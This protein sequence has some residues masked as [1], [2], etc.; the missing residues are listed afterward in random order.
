M[1]AAPRGH[2]KGLRMWKWRRSYPL[3]KEEEVV[4]ECERL[5]QIV[6]AIEESAEAAQAVI[7][8]SAERIAALDAE[9]RARKAGHQ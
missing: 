1:S 9:V 6:K 8:S 7:K 4:K 5:D 3:P 2:Q